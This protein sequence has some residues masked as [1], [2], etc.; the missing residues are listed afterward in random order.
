MI[1]S[2]SDQALILRRQHQIDEQDRQSGKIIDGRVAG[3]DLLVGQFRPFELHALRQHI[4]SSKSV[5]M[6]AWAWPVE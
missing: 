1:E 6:A 3:Q 4:V 5:V 2:G